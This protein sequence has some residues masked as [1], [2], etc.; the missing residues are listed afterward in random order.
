MSIFLPSRTKISYNI[1]DWCYLSF[2]FLRGLVTSAIA[3]C[4]QFYELSL[5]TGAEATI[6]K[7]SEYVLYLST[8]KMPCRLEAASELRGHVP[9][10]FLFRSTLMPTDFRRLVASKRTRLARS[11]SVTAAAT[12]VAW[13]F[14][15]KSRICSLSC[16]SGR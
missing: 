8:T 3:P 16:P 6:S 1:T 5:Y 15:F 13:G 14:L 11:S 4:E 2:L 12:A 7:I 9:H 10:I